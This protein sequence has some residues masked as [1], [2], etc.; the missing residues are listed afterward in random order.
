MI[1]NE[2]IITNI[3]NNLEK[4]SEKERVIAI[5]ITIEIVVKKWLLVESSP[6][7]R[8]VDNFGL[9]RLSIESDQSSDDSKEHQIIVG[10]KFSAVES[11]QTVQ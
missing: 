10:N 7:F 1:S 6:D 8:V 3:M 2:E 11:A 5:I 9:D 4:R